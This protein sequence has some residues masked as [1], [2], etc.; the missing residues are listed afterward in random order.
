MP[1]KKPS[2]LSIEEP[3]TKVDVTLKHSNLSSDKSEKVLYGSINYKKVTVRQI[4]AEMEYNNSTNLSKELMF[5]VAE[6][7][8][9]RMMNK[10]RQGRAVELLDFGTIYPT[11][12]GKIKAGDTASKI[13]EHLDIGFTPSKEAKAALKN[14]VVGNIKQVRPQHAIYSVID[15]MDEEQQENTLKIGKIGRITGKALK[16]GGHESG[17]YAA[18]AEKK[19]GR[20]A[21]E[22]R[23]LD[24][25]RA[26][27]HE[28]PVKARIFCG[29][30]ESWHI[31]PNSPDKPERGR[32][33]AQRKRNRHQRCRNRGGMIKVT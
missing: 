23:K 17:L 5:Y 30:P 14:L 32:E 27:I 8:S 1:R 26:C 9:N 31:Y 10:L 7:L 16:L 24:S 2:I 20:P 15:I 29:R 22:Q 19:M 33:S 12:K 11:L 28:S 3:K 13:K 25:L 18:K 4:L 6:E 21:P